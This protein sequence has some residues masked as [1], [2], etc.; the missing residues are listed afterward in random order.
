MSEEGVSIELGRYEDPRTARE[1]L[2][3]NGCWVHPR[4]E[5]MFRQAVTRRHITRCR[6]VVSVLSVAELEFPAGGSY[7]Q[8]LKH[9]ATLDFNPCLP[10]VAYML[11]LVYRE[12][13]GK[14][15]LWV[16]MDPILNELGSPLVF[17]LTR[18]FGGP[19]L[20]CDFAHP[21]TRLLPEHKIVFVKY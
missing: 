13:N 11:R 20:Y 9:A 10:E 8:I 7:Q 2:T 5:D 14:E 3:T 19:L 12:K 16:A 4:A 21:Y 1:A 17:A 15:F 6:I 18:G